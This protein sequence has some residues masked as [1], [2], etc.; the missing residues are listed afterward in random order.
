MFVNRFFWPD[1]SAT[2]QILSDLAFD[3]AASGMPVRVVTSRHRHDGGDG[4]LP[5]SETAQGVVIDRIWS[6]RSKLPGLVGR[7]LD[8]ITF[9]L[10]AAWALWRRVDR[11][12]IVVC[13]TDPPL[14]SLVAAPVVKLRGATLVNW[15]QDLFPEVAGALG[16]KG[17]RGGPFRLLQRARN[18][19]LRTAATNVILGSRMEELLAGQGNS[20]ASLRIIPNWA[21]GDAIR[22]LDASLNPLRAEW[23][24]ADKFVVGYSGN[25]GRAHEFTTIL[26]AAKVLA[27]RTDIAFLFIGGGAQRRSVEEAVA[28]S[29]LSNIHF[30]PY[31]PRENLR[32]SL[33]VADAHLVSLN[34][35]LEG[36]IVPSK[37]YGIAAAGRATLFIGDQDGEIPR[38]LREGDC[39]LS[40]DIG[41][42]EGLAGAVRALADDRERCRELGQ[43]ARQ[44]FDA[45][46]ERKQAVRAWREVLQDARSR[47]S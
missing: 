45:R 32:E 7:A 44:L 20:P 19:S 15:L 12:T 24:L 27:S 9:Y 17:V 41:D 35:A 36:L 8:Y 40:I 13:K 3:L 29:G 43:N 33:G 5:V 21:D 34:P 47:V 28:Q 23:G 1:Q 18:A 10:S 46:F 25:L 38:V 6:T 30:R 22:P 4:G 14:L 11:K 2:S 42:A 26:D 31:Q 39:G 37:F 16:V